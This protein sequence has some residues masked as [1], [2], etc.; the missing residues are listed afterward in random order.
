VGAQPVWISLGDAAQAM[1]VDG[2]IVA[3]IYSENVGPM[4]ADDPAKGDAYELWWIPV[5][6][7]DAREVIFGVGDKAVDAWESRWDRARAAATW[8][9]DEFQQEH[10][11]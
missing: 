10:D 1:I 11:S 9:Q 5:K 6:N 4:Y 7:P 2:E 3:V 8:M